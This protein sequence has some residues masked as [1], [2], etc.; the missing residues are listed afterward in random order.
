MPETTPS[1]AEQSSLANSSSSPAAPSTVKI[2]RFHQT[3][4]ADVLQLEDMPLP[5]PGAARSACAFRP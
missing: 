2:V 5:E 3:G 1:A 4:G